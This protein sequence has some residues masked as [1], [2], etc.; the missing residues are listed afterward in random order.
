MIN[1]CYWMPLIAFDYPDTLR[2]QVSSDTGNS[3]F[4]VFGIHRITTEHLLAS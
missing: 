4:G 1:D 2:W 3:V